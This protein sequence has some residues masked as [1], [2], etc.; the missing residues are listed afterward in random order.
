MTSFEPAYI[1]TSRTGLLKKKVD[2]ACKILSACTLCP[3]RCKVDRRSGETGVCMTA[4]KAYV[5]SY[6]PHFG[7]EAPLVGRH[8]SGT[9][10]FTHC[11]LLCLFC[12]NFDISHQGVG[13]SVS[14]EQLANIMM[15]LQGSGCHNINF[16]TP[17]HVVP[18]ILSAVEIAVELGLRVPLV[19]NSSGYDS[20]QTL[21]LLE[22]IFD[23]F[24]PDFKFWDAD[25][26]QKTCD[27]EDY[28][29][30]A[31]Q[32]LIEMHRQVGDL[33]T[34]A[35]G[36]A[37]R[38]VLLR[39]LVLPH[40]LAGTR[41]VMKFVAERVSTNTYVNIMP[42]YRPC[43]RAAE[44]KELSQHLSQKDF[45]AALEAARQEGIGRLDSRRRRF[46]LW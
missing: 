2:Q 7:E 41:Q 26:A 6:S 21:K 17:S 45:Q 13:E 36:I 40:G 3:R 5:S 39:H 12:Q 43:G 8:G 4:D 19:Y 42:Q 23:I 16:V 30:V 9:V 15:H 14:N 11:N 28:P 32:A 1:E 10:F 24:M 20:L 22:G 38:G 34:D 33:A 37:Q 44:I 29:E 27:A 25:V 31:R 46:M 18:Q 35:S